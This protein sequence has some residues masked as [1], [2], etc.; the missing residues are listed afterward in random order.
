M[1]W[2]RITLVIFGAL[3]ITALGIDAADTIQGSQSTL[4]SR[5][6][7]PTTDGC[8]QGMVALD[9]HPTLKCVDV[10]EVSTGP[11][12]STQ[13]PEQN[14]ATV[15]NIG[16]KECIGV[17]ESNTTPW[18]F[19]TRD[20]ALQICARS[21]KRLPTSEEWYGLVLGMAN[22]EGSCNVRSK[23]TSQTGAYPDCVSPQGAYDLVGNV[24][25]WVSDDVINGMHKSVKLPDSGY[26]AQVDAA[27]MTTVV[28]EEPQELFDKDYFWSKSEG[29]FSMI[30]GGFYDS[31]SDGGIFTVHADIVPT[32][33]SG[34]IGFRCVK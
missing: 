16:E 6:I 29:A 3:I 26:I 32:S 17:S 9:N 12:C 8:P 20:Q 30:R 24:W 33:A 2:G 25:E 27:G 19:V 31:G 11:K 21:G 22:V 7:S 1:K 15:R 13:D 10:Y 14:L 5:V 34:G 4:L 23:N 28:S 18:R